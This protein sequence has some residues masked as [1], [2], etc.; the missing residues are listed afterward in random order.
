[1]ISGHLETRHGYWYAVLN[2]RDEQGNRKRKTF[3]THL[4]VKGN[5]KRAEEFLTKLRIKHT[6]LEDIRRN[7]RGIFFDEYMASWVAGM[8]GKVSPTT[9]SS[10]KYIVQNSICPYFREQGILLGDLKPAHIEKYYEFLRKSGLSN[11]TIIRHHANL[12]KALAEA[13]RKDLIPFNPASRVQRPKTED[14]ISNPYTVEEANL[15]LEAV[16]DEKLELV[17]TLTLFYGL[18]RGEVLGLRWSAVDFEKNTITINHSV[19]QANVDGKY[20]VLHQDKLKRTS[21]FRTMPLI[22]SIKELLLKVKQMRNPNE[23]DYICINDKGQV[24][25]PNYVTQEFSKLLKRHHL[26]PIRFHD[27]RRSCASLL[28]GQRVPLIEVQQWLGHS[29]IATTA[30]LYSHLDF[31]TKLNSAETIKKN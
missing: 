26:R 20:A 9:Y 21:S 12:H 29:T 18:R 25:K 31:V 13:C 8:E 19:T 16:K 3:A 22:E 5:K 24:I 7:S 27:L 14:F 10:Y 11:N 4:P 17:V 6:G 28:I 30:D 15:L 1:M 2:L 23:E